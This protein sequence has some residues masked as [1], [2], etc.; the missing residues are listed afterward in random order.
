MDAETITALSDALSGPASG[1]FV[2]GAILFGIYKVAVNLL[3]PF[4]TTVADHI[5]EG[6]ESQSNSLAALVEEVKKDREDHREM[7]SR[8]VRVEEDVVEIKDDI[9]QIKNK[10]VA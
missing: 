4:L 8:L 6:F 9:T 2:M 7:G 10:I 5:K 3:G 1:L